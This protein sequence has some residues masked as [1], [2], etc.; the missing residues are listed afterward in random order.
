MKKK[1]L[2]YMALLLIAMVA[3]PIQ[4]SAKKKIQPKM[5]AFGFAMSL[6]DSTAYFT[7]IMSVDSVW[8]DSKNNFV[9]NRYDYTEQFRSYLDADKRP[10][11]LC[12][13]IFGKTEKAL[14]S[15]YKKLHKRYCNNKKRHYA[16][17][18]I[19]SF[20][21]RSVETTSMG[22]EIKPKSLTTKKGK[23]ADKKR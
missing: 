21:L 5:F 11:T 1:I 18:K 15:K 3:F 4:T 23:K 12:T 13:V 22:L 17:V 2:F 19:D 6:V 20:K 7:D 10:T 16:I 9:I 14:A 8:V